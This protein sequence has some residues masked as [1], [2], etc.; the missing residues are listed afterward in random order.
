[1]AKIPQLNR[2]FLRNLVGMCPNCD[3][4]INC[5]LMALR[6]TNSLRGGGLD[7]LGYEID[8]CQII[9]SDGLLMRRCYSVT[10]KEC[11]AVVSFFWKRGQ[12]DRLSIAC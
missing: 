12:V 2:T 8:K 3:V 5:F 9:L 11:G 1:M 6:S 4:E 10:L 7:S